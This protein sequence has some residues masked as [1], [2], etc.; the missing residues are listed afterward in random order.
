MKTALFISKKL[1]NNNQTP[2]NKASIKLA[3]LALLLSVITS[4]VAFGISSGF[5]S[6]IVNKIKGVSGNLYIR[7]ASLSR[8]LEDLP[9]KNSDEIIN[10]ILIGNSQIEHFQKF[11]TKTSVL[12]KNRDIEGII[13]K[14]IDDNFSYKFFNKLMVKG[15]F[16]NY[17]ESNV[18]EIVLP[19]TIANKLDIDTN[20]YITAYFTDTNLKTRILKVV[21]IYSTDIADI[22]NIYA[23]S[24][25]KLIQKINN[26]HNGQINGI[27]IF[28]KNDNISK[29]VSD[30]LTLNLPGNLIAYSDKE[31]FPQIFDW[32]NLIDKNSIIILSLML[33]VSVINLISSFFIIIIEKTS[34]I[35]LF[36]AFGFPDSLVRKI[37]IYNIMRLMNRY[38]ILGNL[39]GISI[40]LIQ[41]KFKLIKLDSS[42]YF[43]KFIPIQLDILTLIYINLAIEI[44]IM[45]TLYIVSLKII[46]IHPVNNLNL[47]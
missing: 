47:K 28:L 25:I 20:E 29:K 18:N 44:A 14:G 43:V 16:I 11:A 42:A 40:C 38:L 23:Y 10:E 46:K 39:I 7:I 3:C 17:N 41:Q 27:E 2:A 1:F 13:I 4:I 5:K 21:G 31:L 19:I 32:L 6:E 33:M 34:V 37:F 9:I 15:R 30:E 35:G 36:K 24:N 45:L 26:W 22:D 12:V 8:S